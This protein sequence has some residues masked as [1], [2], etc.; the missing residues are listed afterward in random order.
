[1]TDVP[2]LSTSKPIRRVN[3]LVI[4]LVAIVIV[5]VLGIF[6]LKL[7]SNSQGVLD[8]GLAPD[9]TIKTYDGSTF[10]LAQQRGKV[11]VINFWASWCGP[12]RSE[13]PDLNAVWDEYQNR[14]VVMVGVG[15]LDN[16]ADARGFIKEFGIHYIAG[17]D[18]G[19]D[20]SRAYR[21]TGVPETYVVGKDG[22]VVASYQVPTNAQQLRGVLDKALA[23]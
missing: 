1:M 15:Y 18:N 19:T 8:S 3:P 17:P 23:Q 9:F 7:V 2:D 10:S 11:V 4:G 22:T 20:V 21:I 13:A 14:G 12:C 5:I 16:D 6:G